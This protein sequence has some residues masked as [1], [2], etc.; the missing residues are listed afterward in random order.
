MSHTE[1]AKYA[2]A[3]RYSS[4]LNR[5]VPREIKTKRQFVLSF[6]MLIIVIYFGFICI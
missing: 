3:R 1:R 4:L 2:E 6:I 5:R